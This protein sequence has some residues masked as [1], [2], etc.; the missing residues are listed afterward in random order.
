MD[1]LDKAKIKSQ[2]IADKTNL[3]VFTCNNL[4]QELEGLLSEI[5]QKNHKK[6]GAVFCID[7]YSITKNGIVEPIRRIDTSIR[8]SIGL[9][10]YMR[11]KKVS[12]LSIDQENNTVIY[13]DMDSD[14]W[15][16]S[17]DAM[18]FGTYAFVYEQ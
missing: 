8:I 10:E 3:A 16:I 9:P 1:T 2:V 12:L 14:S 17:I 13:E 5:A 11:G 4:N 15:T 6:V 18:I 7:L